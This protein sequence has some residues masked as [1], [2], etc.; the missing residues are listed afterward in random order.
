VDEV[1]EALTHV[2]VREGGY[3]QVCRERVRRRTGVRGKWWM[4]GEGLVW[5][6][7]M[8]LFLSVPLSST[9]FL[10]FFFPL[11]PTSSRSSLSLSSHTADPPPLIP[12]FPFSSSFLSFTMPLVRLTS[13]T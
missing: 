8:F 10:R 9:L 6:N 3:I 7:K 5:V 1:A 12:P 13:L 11:S 4:R 2:R